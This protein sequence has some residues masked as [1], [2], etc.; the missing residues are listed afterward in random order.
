MKMFGYF[1]TLQFSKTGHVL[2]NLY[3]SMNGTNKIL[4]TERGKSIFVHLR[5]FEQT[6]FFVGSL[7]RRRKEPGTKRMNDHS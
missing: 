6:C 5:P 1:E 7:V 4:M 2:Y 3:L